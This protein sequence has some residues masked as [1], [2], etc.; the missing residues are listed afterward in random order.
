MLFKS[1]DHHLFTL[2]IKS[3]PAYI[4]ALSFAFQRL[5]GIASRAEQPRDD[6]DPLRRQYAAMAIHV[7]PMNPVI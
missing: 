3:A 5:H 7:L 4:D 2:H 6:I 1:Q